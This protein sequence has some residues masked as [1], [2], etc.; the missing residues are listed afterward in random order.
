MTNKEKAFGIIQAA[1][2]SAGGL[3][4]GMAQIPFADMPALCAIE[5]TMVIALGA[6]FGK[7][8]DEST[9]K[10]ILAAYVGTNVGTSI[11]KAIVGIFP[12]IGNAVNAG[13]AVTVVETLGWAIY[14]DFSSTYTE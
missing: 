4:A 7:Q 5:I 3:S 1:A 9:A 2:C 6:L 12:V 11:F 14:A 8:L 13:I 10:G